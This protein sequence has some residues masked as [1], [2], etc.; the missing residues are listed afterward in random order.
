LHFA[1][2]L[3]CVVSAAPSS[4]AVDV[5]ETQTQPSRLEDHVD[6]VV[7][8]GSHGPDAGAAHYTQHHSVR[9]QFTAAAVTPAE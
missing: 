6:T 9:G 7:E 1:L 8:C 2:T 5:A 4:V 3:F